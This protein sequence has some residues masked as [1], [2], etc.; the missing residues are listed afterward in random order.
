MNG[1]ILNVVQFDMK[2]LDDMVYLIKLEI[3]EENTDYCDTMIG[4]Y[5]L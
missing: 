3:F 1:T 2:I 4:Y 5:C